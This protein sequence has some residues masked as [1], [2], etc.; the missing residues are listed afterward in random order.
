MNHIYKLQTDPFEVSQL[1]RVDSREH[2]AA[3]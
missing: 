1:T 2:D 3:E